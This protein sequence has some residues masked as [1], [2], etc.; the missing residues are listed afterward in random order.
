MAF[1]TLLRIELTRSRI[2][3]LFI[4]LIAAFA[5]TDMRLMLWG[6][7]GGRT[8]FWIGGTAEQL[9]G[10]F[11][12]GTAFAAWY[13]GRSR[14]NHLDE[15][16][17]STRWLG[18]GSHATAL[19][20]MVGVLI[21]TVVGVFATVTFR[22]R[23]NS[24]DQLGDTPT[25]PYPWLQILVILTA[26]AAFIGWGYWLGYRM[27]SNLAL[28]VAAFAMN[29]VLQLSRRLSFSPDSPSAIGALIPTRIS[30][31]LAPYIGDR[32]YLPLAF[33]GIAWFAVV[34]LIP[35]LMLRERDVRQWNGKL[36]AAVVT[37]LVIVC[38]T[39][40][41]AALKAA[42]SWHAEYRPLNCI[43][44]SGMSFCAPPG[45]LSDSDLEIVAFEYDQLLPSWYPATHLPDRLSIPISGN[46]LPSNAVTMLNFQYPQERT[47]AGYT[48]AI[49]YLIAGPGHIELR[50]T[51]AELVVVCA[52]LRDT[53]HNC[54][55]PYPQDSSQSMPD[56]NDAREA[57]ELIAP[58]LSSGQQLTEAEAAQ[59]ESNLATLQALMQQKL[60]NFAALSS[61]EKT[62]WLENHW[63]QLRSGNMT[64]DDLP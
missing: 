11:P 51:A 9:T 28:L 25:G 61:E 42:G 22:I 30:Y 2:W 38:A 4:V 60:D 21:L 41:S 24:I 20:A 44:R 18:L 62:T 1:L 7:F 48:R 5:V 3:L 26:F 8:W 32:V 23:Q 27:K 40:V 31:A 13:A 46:Q 53:G 17:I 39:N 6:Q 33:W 58:F 14:R 54:G 35:L 10:V 36:Q 37:V 45:A 43:E 52:M 55:V 12:F 49:L 56:A 57:Q 29:F 50:P 59:L 19:V 34:G 64:L 16:D 63:D 47:S 15:V